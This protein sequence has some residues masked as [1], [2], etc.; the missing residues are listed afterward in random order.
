MSSPRTW[1][2]I[3]RPDDPPTTTPDNQEQQQPQPKTNQAVEKTAAPEQTAQQTTP[4][5][6]VETPP[7]PPND[8]EELFTPR[9]GADTTTEGDI[10]AGNVT[11]NKPGVGPTPTVNLTDKNGKTILAR[12][13]YDPVRNQYA[14]P[15]GY[16]LA[17]DQSA[18]NT[19]GVTREGKPY[20]T[21][22]ASKKYTIPEYMER[23]KP[24]NT[25]PEGNGDAEDELPTDNTTLTDDFQLP[26]ETAGK[27]TFFGDDWQKLRDANTSPNNF[28]RE[29]QAGLIPDEELKR[30]ERATSRINAVRHLG[31]I[32]NAFS[33]LYYTRGGAPSQ[34]LPTVKDPDLTAWRNS[35]TKNLESFQKWHDK[36][37]EAIWNREYRLMKQ[38]HRE[39]IDRDRIALQKEETKMRSEVKKWEAEKR[40]YEAGSAQYKQ[41]EAKANAAKKEYEAKEAEI[42]A[43]AA[44]RKAEDDHAVAMSIKNKNDAEAQAKATESAA[45]ATV[46]AAEAEKKRA[47]ANK[48]T[49][50]GNAATKN[51]NTNAK[52]GVAKANYYNNGGSSGNTT[53]TDKPK[54]NFRITATK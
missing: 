38:A 15:K 13:N 17:P 20:I 26:S 45:K 5:T 18:T 12:V 48:A 24:Q 9:E 31:N 3:S 1:Q 7:P 36:K 42:K 54:V 49:Q 23:D 27:K 16:Q 46:A 41:A 40:K 10:T 37:D 14:I 34:T 32:L 43:N 6:Q 22:K 52:V 50:Q 11:P 39:E 21:D 33:N 30:R 2:Q 4:P 25:T 29:W 19:N 28:L 44:K 8:D 53:T 35:Q 51:A 47:E